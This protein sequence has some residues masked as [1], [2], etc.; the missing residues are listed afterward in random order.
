MALDFLK[1]FVQGI[2]LGK[3]DLAHHWR[4]PGIL[5]RGALGEA[6][7]ALNGRGHGTALWENAGALWSMPIGPRSSPA[8]MRLP[9]GEGE[10]PRIV[11]NSDG[12]GVALWQ[13][14]VMGEKQLLG[15]VLGS[16]DSMAHVIFWTN[17]QI[18]HLQAAADRRG[19]A[20]VVWLHEKAGQ[21]EV[22][23]QSFDARTETWEQEP[24]VLSIPSTESLKPH[25][26][27]NDRERAMVLWEVHGKEFE[28]LVASHYWPSDRIWSDRP[29]PVVSHATLHHQV[30]MDD[31]GNAMAIWI[32]APHGQRSTLEASFYNVQRCEWDEPLVLASAQSMTPPRIVMTGNGEALAAWCQGEGRGPARLYCKAFTKGKWDTAVECLDAGQGGVRDFAIALDSEGQAGLLAVHQ[33]ADVQWVSARLRQGDWSPPMP[34]SQASQA[35]CSSPRLA[36]CPQG[37]SALWIQGEGHNKALMLS[38]TT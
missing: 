20:L 32:H 18:S 26:A 13:S 11:M 33:G 16:G 30:V 27:V 9:M 14:E 4:T 24:T 12:R 10:N 37:A 23:A 1:R 36:I 28:G 31:P 3:P 17:G 5:D 29:V 15:K 22:M 38:E 34:F 8:L 25:I 35:P 2:S 6:R 7:L 21:F 19:N